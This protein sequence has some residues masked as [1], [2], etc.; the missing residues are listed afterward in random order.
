MSIRAIFSAASMG[1]RRAAFSRSVVVFGCVLAF[2]TATFNPAFADFK[3]VGPDKRSKA[4]I[5][6]D[7]CEAQSNGSRQVIVG[8][9]LGGLIG[10]AIGRNNYVKD[11]M[12]ARGYERV[13][14]Q[15]KKVNTVQKKKRINNNFNSKKD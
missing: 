14:A 15:K 3:K 12:K 4:Q 6:E 8:A 10:Q 1:L 13:S 11:C 9:V 5:A 7:E 2:A